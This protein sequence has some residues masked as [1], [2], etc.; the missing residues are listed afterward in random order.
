MLA[1]K[2]DTFRDTCGDRGY[3]GEEQCLSKKLNRSLSSASGEL[4][5]SGISFS[6]G[7]IEVTKKE[8]VAPRENKSALQGLYLFDSRTS[9]A[10]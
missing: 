10:M 6:F 4:I 5:D 7:S 3:R 1:N 2:L 9:G 8:R